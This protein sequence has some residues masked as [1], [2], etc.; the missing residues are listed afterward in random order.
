MH[1]N[2]ETE[3][4]GVR[5]EDIG[6]FRL[7]GRLGEG[8][9]GVV[10]RAEHK[11]SGQIV[12]LKTVRVQG[13]GELASLRREIHTL[14]Q[15]RHPGVVRILDEG[16]QDG[17]PWYAMELVEGDTLR[18]HVRRLRAAVEARP[19]PQPESPHEEPCPTLPTSRPGEWAGS[20]QATRTGQADHRS[21]PT[22]PRLRGGA[23]E[24][25]F[26][27]G[28]GAAPDLED[29]PGPSRPAQV[30]AQDAGRNAAMRPA[31][32]PAFVQAVLSVVQRLARVL[33]FLHGEGIV[34]RDLKPSNVLM[35]KV[36][37]ARGEERTASAEAP[38]PAILADP[39]AR[40]DASFMPVL[41]DFGLVARIHGEL[42][43]E[44]LAVASGASGTV[45]YMAPEQV[46]GEPVDARAD[47]YSLGCILYELLTG[48]TPFMGA[49]AQLV[50]AA[51]LF[52][53]PIPLSSRVEGIAP[54]LDELVLRL[55]AKQPRER[56]GHADDVAA[57]L[58]RLGE[59]DPLGA[60][61]P[62][63]RP[64]LYRPGFV[65]RADLMRRLS[66]HLERLQAG[67]G[68]TV[69][70]SGESGAGKTRL[71]VEL[72]RVAAEARLLVLAGECA[73]GSSPLQ[74]L[75]RPLQAV[76]DRCRERGAAETQRI[77]GAGG[78]VLALHEPA[79]AALPGLEA[80]PEPAE[81]PADAA[82]QRLFVSTAEVF[83]ALS[84][85]GP[86]LLLL[87][88]LQWAD[89]LTLGALGV[90]LRTL[91]LRPCP[92]LL[93]GAYRADEVR[94]A[95]PVLFQTL[96]EAPQLDAIGLSRL[97]AR[98]VAQMASEMLAW[99]KPP[100][101]LLD[102]LRR[103]A[104]G[105]PFF[106]A[107]LL[108]A[109]VEAG[110]VERDQAGRWRLASAE[111]R[112]ADPLYDALSLPR[113]LQD[114]VHRRLEGLSP[115]ARRVAQVASVLGR[116]T[117]LELLGKV[118]ANSSVELLDA[119]A[120]LVRRQI[121]EPSA[122]GSLRFV[123]DKL[124]E[125]A[126]AQLDAAARRRLHRA[127]AEALESIG[128][129][130]S[131]GALAWHWEAAGELERARRAYLASARH[132]VKQYAHADAERLYG[133]FVD[134][135]ERPTAETACARNE[136]GQAVLELQGR[137][138]EALAQYETAHKEARDVG[139]RREEAQ[140]LRHL[141][142]LHKKTGRMDE[143]RAALEQSLALARETGDRAAE[144]ESLS[145]LASVSQ[146]Q[147]RFEEAFEL[148]RAARELY[149]LARDRASEGRVL[150]NLA[151]LHFHF[152]QYL[153]ARPLFEQSLAI[154][155]EVGSRRN[156]GITLGNL[157]SLFAVQGRLAEAQVLFEQSL[158]LAREIGS[159]YSEGLLLGN[160]GL[161][162]A[163]QGR[164]EQAGA[165]HE[166]SLAIKR[167]L[168]DRPGEGI[169][170]T[171]LGLLRLSE[172][173]PEEAS[174]LLQAALATSL[175]VSRRRDVRTLCGL[176]S[177]ERRAAGAFDRAQAWLDQGR[178]ATAESTNYFTGLW[179]CEQGHLELAQG[180]SAEVSLS[181]AR[182]VARGLE[183]NR[184][185]ELGLAL[186]R[187]ERAQAQFEA[188]EPLFRGEC[189]E[190]LPEGLRRWL[191]KAGQLPAR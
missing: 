24:T 19:E 174:G 75:R 89:D 101:Q 127:S 97:D 140:S 57:A 59:R 173:R 2:P 64:Y 183:A 103:H 186:R 135:A 71:L 11:E 16:V 60:A 164:L 182:R 180:G 80:Y 181:A 90:L 155:R 137:M 29:W 179:L 132:A 4:P 94:E 68:G 156:E 169:T 130:S 111:L 7:L 125:G 189:E 23:R 46:R 61:L 67:G 86:I 163:T 105:N 18:R 91:Q 32:A 139:A 162:H 153:E 9:M 96:R 161:L 168:G 69:L 82:R 134:L 124:R 81:L 44:E 131:P 87:D 38:G 72:A 79:F 188:G 62:R 33:A 129:E 120:E 40:L 78:R 142:G 149:R 3:G 30:Q 138:Q 85:A 98:A 1:R 52:D 102:F 6:P 58:E 56:I 27:A 14:A 104:E 106:I 12:A 121:L 147:G 73:L 128:S 99:S 65:G 63:P 48:R 191:A 151:D 84:Q 157:G 42:S 92:L 34:H 41:V 133:R 177:I 146:A 176:A 55:L 187:L 158:A 13:A 166:Q 109:A 35:R 154:A 77:A 25:S 54:E 122:G 159:R 95:D 145:G 112:G 28:G 175:E 17:V 136:L 148:Y 150:G 53:E 165:L 36:P 45:S 167:Q 8:G 10:Y 88:D 37:A 70:I 170:L 108:R 172:G 43:R 178:E 51:H 126:Y 31:L 185:S 107:E 141:G 123:H 119:T 93:V 26:G 47:L 5:R 114:L 160:L 152:D 76:A 113:S 50:L 116:E 171:N 49:T 39:E 74:A 66:S 21:E 83:A 143:A 190:D 144:A 117:E 115:G 110:L 20:Q 118:A 184:H 15:V 22:A 100:E